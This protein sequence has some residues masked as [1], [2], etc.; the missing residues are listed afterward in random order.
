MKILSTEDQERFSRHISLQDIG[1]SGQQKLKNARVLVIGTGGLG[2]PLIIYLAAAGVGCLGLV[3]DD[4]VSLSNLQRQVLYTTAQVG[5]KKVEVAAQRIKDLYPEIEVQSYDSRLT[6]DNASEL[7]GAYD[8]VVDCSDNYAT[9]T[10]IGSVSSELDKPLVY[11]SV[12]NY[13]GQLTVFNFNNGPSFKQLYPSVPKDGI[14]KTE[15]IGLV[16]VLPG[17]T[18]SLQAN[19]VLKIITGYGEV[20][21]GKLLVFSIDKNRFQVF[22]Y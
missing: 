20:L 7:I 1:V 10:L 3:D 21:S 19:E 12:L 22:K 9:R 2:S 11:A 4:V 6:A 8:I 5:Q 14:Y 15:D 17:I 16:G 13:E 18:G